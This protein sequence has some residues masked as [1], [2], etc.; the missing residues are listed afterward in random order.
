MNLCEFVP[1]LFGGRGLCLSCLYPQTMSPVLFR[2]VM[3][4]WLVPVPSQADNISQVRLPVLGYA[5]DY[6]PVLFAAAC[7]DQICRHDQRCVASL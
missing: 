6:F 2:T 7:L 3:L 1:R 4:R 5:S